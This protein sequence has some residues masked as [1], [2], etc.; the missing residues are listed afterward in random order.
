MTIARPIPR[1]RGE[2]QVYF[3]EAKAGRLAFQRCLDCSAHIFYLR[4]ACPECLSER[5]ELAT[6]SGRGVVHSFTTL[7]IAGNKAFADEVPY[8]VVL[9]DLEEH[10]RVLA[11]LDGVDP[12]E[13][14]VGMEVEV[15]F[16]DVDDE[17]TVPRFR[18][19][20]SNEEVPA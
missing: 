11:D 16:E 2:E 10:V 8:T 9:V 12:E 20:Q 18:R 17:F 7:H 4:S 3:A 19:A 1:L 13:V 14:A 15:F 6:S 5:L